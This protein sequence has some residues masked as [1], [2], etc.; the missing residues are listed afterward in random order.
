MLSDIP[1]GHIS[2]HAAKIIIA[3]A[4]P[5]HNATQA[6][7]QLGKLMVWLDETELASRFRSGAKH[8]QDPRDFC[9]FLAA[10]EG[11]HMEMIRSYISYVPLT[12]KQ[13]NQHTPPRVED[14]IEPF[15]NVEMFFNINFPPTAESTGPHEL[16]KLIEDSYKPDVID[17]LKCQG[18]GQNMT[19]THLIH[20]PQD[21]MI[22][23]PD[24]MRQNIMGQNDKRHD[25]VS[26]PQGTFNIASK[27]QDPVWMYIRAV[28]HHV[29][30]GADSGH[31]LTFIRDTPSFDEWIRLNDD[32]VVTDRPFSE[33]STSSVYMILCTKTGPPTAD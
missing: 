9:L 17:G 10:D 16:V 1:A 8:Q 21:I 20:D 2:E 5:N 29:G 18:C 13:C 23:L 11:L 4:R 32:Q 27:D 12:R 6:F 24:R 25:L 28:I 33:V 15:E 22:V 3:L 19:L 30:S 7:Q 31:Y 26:L 14:N